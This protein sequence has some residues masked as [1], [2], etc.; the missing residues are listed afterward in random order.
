MCSSD[1]EL[2]RLGIALL[3]PDVNRSEPDFAVELTAKG[4]QAIR[5][6]LGA[7]RNVGFQAMQVLTSDRRTKGPFKSLFDLAE[8]LGLARLGAAPSSVHVVVMADGAAVSLLVDA[9]GDV[10]EVTQAG[11]EYPPDTLEDWLRE[12]IVGVH[13]LEDRLLLVLDVAR[14]VDLA[15]TATGRAR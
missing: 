12:L 14:A 3:P 11:F 1:L 13:K 10:V 15:G 4:E 8:R 6:A 7:V 2:Q 9:V 5:Y